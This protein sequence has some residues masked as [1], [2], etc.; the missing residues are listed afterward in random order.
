MN[1]KTPLT[2]VVLILLLVGGTVVGWHYATQDVPSLRDAAS[3]DEPETACRTY[4][5]GSKLK[6][7]AVTVN[8]YNA[9]GIPNLAGQT[10]TEF[11][12][13]GFSGGV[14]ENAER[15]VPGKSVLLL[16]VEPKSAQVR[17][18]RK[19]LQ[20]KVRSSAPET[21]TES[22]A[23]DVYLGPKFKG[24]VRQAPDSVRVK[25][26]TRVCYEIDE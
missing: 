1:W 15:K 3:A 23:I 16:A 19:Q 8:V 20:G 6:T 17:L 11:V 5:S 4:D 13:R 21:T 18:V 7:G 12:E 24:F 9:S 22:T 14:I 25:G 2:M 10:M 26:S